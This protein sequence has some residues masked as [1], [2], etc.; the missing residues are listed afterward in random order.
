M[1][2]VTCLAHALHR[3]AEEIRNQFPEVDE[4]IS[5]V[6]K[7]FLKAPSRVVH[8]K[9]VAPEVPLPPSPVLTRW[10]TWLD[11]CNYYCENINV[12]K[13]IIDTFDNSDA[14]SI[15]RAKE[16]L[17]NNEVTGKLLYIKSNFGFLSGAITCLE[18][19]NVQLVE[20]INLIK[21]VADDLR[22]VRGEMGK[23]VEKKMSMVLTKNKGYAVMCSI[24]DI[25]SGENFSIGE[26]PGDLNPSDIVYFKY[27][28]IVTVEVERSFSMYK[29]LLRDNRQSFSFENLQQLFVVHCNAGLKKGK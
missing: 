6:K 26:L 13:T 21:N 5:C 10:G 23:A 20:Q 12:V 8:F 18:K 28:P 2:H 1:V 22:K 19:S 25:L 11:A 14:A 24:C 3:V 9:S 17:P 29:S 27:A 15:K 16:I 7:V 4:L